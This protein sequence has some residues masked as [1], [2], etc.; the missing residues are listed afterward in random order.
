[1]TC[2]WHDGRWHRWTI[3]TRPG[4][5]SRRIAVDGS[6]AQAVLPSPYA[7][8]VELRGVET[9]ASDEPRQVA[10]EQDPP[11]LRE[12]RIFRDHVRGGP[13]PPTTAADGFEVVRI[14]TE[15]RKSAD[16]C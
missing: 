14:I 15:I 8:H 7:D 3:S 6:R 13:A 9:A 5:V 12:L 16:L 2:H 4:A 10:V 1:V 11:L